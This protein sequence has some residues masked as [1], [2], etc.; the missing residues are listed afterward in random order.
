M[1]ISKELLSC[2]EQPEDLL[3]NDGSMKE[4]K[5]KLMELM[6]G[7]ELTTHHSYEDGKDAPSDQPTGAMAP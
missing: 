2:C 4:L 1:T 7:T 6:L 3:G 5:V